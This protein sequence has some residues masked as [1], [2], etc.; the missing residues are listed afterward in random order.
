[1]LDLLG[2]LTRFRQF[3]RHSATRTQQRRNPPFRISV[4]TAWSTELL[5]DRS[6]LSSTSLGSEAAS[7]VTA[8]EVSSLDGGVSITGPA[9]LKDINTQPASSS[10]GVHDNDRN[11][12][13]YAVL[14]GIAYFFANDGVHGRELWRTDGTASGTWYVADINP[15]SIGSSGGGVSGSEPDDS[16]VVAAG[17]LFFNA[18]DGVHGGELWTS[19]G[20]PEGTHLVKDVS[21]VQYYHGLQWLTSVDDHVYYIQNLGSSQGTELVVSYGT[22]DSTFVSDLNPGSASSIPWQLSKVGSDV[23]FWARD[24]VHGWEP[25]SSSGYG[26]FREGDLFPGVGSSGLSEKFTDVNGNAFFVAE[27]DV[28][29]RYLFLGGTKLTTPSP[30]PGENLNTTNVNGTFFFNASDATH[31]G[32][33]WKFD[34]NPANMTLVKDINPGTD[35]SVPGDMTLPQPVN[36]NGMLFFIANDGTHGLE[37]WKSDGSEGGTQLI[38]DLTPGAANST[39]TSLVTLGN[40]VFFAFDDGVHGRELWKTDGTDVGTQMVKDISPGSAGPGP[41][42]MYQ[43]NGM[44]LFSADDGV[45]GTE[46]WRTDG[47]AAGTT[48][49]LDI[50]TNTLSSTATDYVDVNGV[51]YFVADDGIHGPELWQTD[52]TLGSTQLVKDLNPG[53][54]GGAPHSLTNVNGTLYF[55]ANDGVTGDELWRTDGTLAATTLVKDIVTGATGSAPES[56]TYFNGK[57]YFVAD[58]GTTGKELWQ[59]DGTDSGTTLVQDIRPG[60]VGS[61]PSSLMEEEGILYFV[62]NDGTTGEELWRTD[63]VTTALFKDIRPGGGSSSPSGLINVNG[64]LYF[65]ADDGTSGRELWKSDRTPAGTVL[66]DDIRLGPAGSA[67]AQ[68]TRVGNRFFFVA[69]NGVTGQELWVSDGTPGGTQLVHDIVTGTGSA[70]ISDLTAL[71]DELYFTADIGGSGREL[72]RSNGSPGNVEQ[73]TLYPGDTGANPDL[74]TV[75]NGELFFAASDGTHG[76]ELWRLDTVT[77][78]PVLVT[79]LQPGPSDTSPAALTAIGKVLY[80]TAADT[81]HG[82]EPWTLL[83]NHPPTDVNLT[84]GSVN[85]KQPV[86]SAVGTLSTVDA[87]VG[88]TFTYSLVADY[89]DNSLF[90]IVGNQIQTAA[91]FDYE[92]KSSYD[93]QVRTTDNGGLSFVRSLVITINDVNESPENIILSNATVPPLSPVNTV[94]GDLAASDPDSGDIPLFT[95]VDSAGGQFAILGNHLVV[96]NQPIPV[97]PTSYS[98]TVQA[99]DPHGLSAT[100]TFTIQV[101]GDNPNVYFGSAIRAGAEFTDLGT[102]VATDTLGNV[103]VTGIVEGDAFVAKYTSSGTPVWTRALVG[104]FGTE[105][106]DITVDAS[107][108]VYWT[109]SFTGTVDFN[110][111]TE[112]YNLSSPT[113]YSGYV[114][115]LD[116]SGNFLW[117]IRY[118]GSGDVNMTGIGLD[119][120][121]NVYTTGDFHNTV[122]FN[123]GTGFKNLTSAGGSDVFVAKLD[124]AGNFGWAVQ[125]GSSGDDRGHDI[126]LDL[127]NSVYITGGFADGAD[128]DPGLGTLLVNTHGSDDAFL[129]KLTSAGALVWAHALGG[130]ATEVGQGVAVDLANDVYL[131]GYFYGDADFDPGTGVCQ[132]QNAGNSDVFALKFHGDGSFVWGNRMGGTSDEQG[133]RIAVDPANNLFVMGLF[134]GIGDFNPGTGTANLTSAGLNDVFI[135]RL[136]ASTG[137]YLWAGSLGGAGQDQAAGLALDGTGALYTVGFFEGTADFDPT[138]GI[139]N[140]ISAGE[141]DLFVSQLTYELSTPAVAI[142]QSHDQLDPTNETAIDFTVVF[143]AAVTGF[144][145]GDVTVTGTAPGSLAATVTPV[146]G[147]GTTYHVTVTGMTGSGTVIATIRAGVAQDI[148]GRS[149]RASTSTDNSVLYD[150]LSPTA[151]L[152]DPA[153]GGSISETVINGRHYLDV[154]FSEPGGSGL[155]LATIL[156]AAP[157]FTVSGISVQ[158]TPVLVSGTTYRYQFTGTLATGPVSVVFLDAG[159]SDIAGNESVAGSQSFMVS[160]LPTLSINDPVIT[161]GDNGSVN[162]T[163]TVTLSTASGVPVSV[164]YATANGSAVAGTDY[165]SRSGTLTFA[166]GATT[167]TIVV[168]VLGDGLIEGNETFVVTLSTP[169]NAVIADGSGVCQIVD[170]D[171]P[172]SVSINDVEVKEKSKG[173]KK[174]VFT[175]SRSVSGSQSITVAFATAD[176]TATAGTDYLAQNGVLT[177]K[178]KQ[179]KLKIKVVVLGD[180]IN[181]SNESF[182]VILSNPVNAILGDGTGTGTILNAGG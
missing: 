26:A 103:Y 159:F 3:T 87:D 140:L 143:S 176:G 75:I 111:G 182:Q 84:P 72:W 20:T 25:Y 100:K 154:S 86:G 27:T 88:D 101:V 23:Y 155:N 8:Q 168:P 145:T 116:S 79:D 19:D 31:G 65:A 18:R 6:L 128:F 138:T 12:D 99:T 112:I 115:K 174:A 71:G 50:N 4:P 14:N 45:H 148:V 74:L 137:N 136:A 61:A 110:P 11:E 117:A 80:Y 38:K 163:F 40:S 93:I 119:T 175:V 53:L 181:E 7:G 35:S 64:T 70:S 52:R 121:E 91:V 152:V 49:V 172:P 55:V 150:A 77:S 178:P 132:L 81:Q 107:G 10:P 94:V 16:M 173:S 180:Q 102:G 13:T 73:L 158:G 170:N 120:A 62:A 32:E 157:E 76:R 97:S 146:G 89:G 30:P 135:S 122:D 131:T 21:P 134:Q 60:S 105:G 124:N 78:S 37:L 15:G 9:L 139:H 130:V 160:A 166:A 22:A 149:N 179:K 57:L 28:D 2:F 69:D 127:L 167:G 83:V 151:N 106:T 41:V 46:L 118:G 56:L 92:A 98:V 165:S 123:P 54:A 17:R 67:P 36:L 63:G 113:N 153:N 104:W 164:N 82:L 33:L 39:I 66:F 162:V 58:D 177:F 144:A 142:N 129:W 109:G 42:G 44:L 5:E 51:T 171:F 59:S 90:S 29:Q 96:A 133:R 147:D 161:E 34:G 47:T 156:D 68:L 48:L 1:V 108:N 24:A 85:E 95:L 43:Y 126:V 114:Q 169:T 125:T 141:T